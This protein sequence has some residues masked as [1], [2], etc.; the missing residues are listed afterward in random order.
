MSDD[1]E[2]PLPEQS[3]QPQQ[4]QPSKDRHALASD[5]PTRQEC[6]RALGR[7]PILITLKVISTQQANAIFSKLAD[8]EH[9]HYLDIGPKFMNEAGV[10]TRGMMPD[11]LHLTGEG[12]AIW[13]D[14]IEA[15]LSNLLGDP[16]KTK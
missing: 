16:P 2:G 7:L 10:L 9:V 15:N 11:R 12:Y 3:P 6:M 1:I 13:A 14:S 8:G 5:V 4:E